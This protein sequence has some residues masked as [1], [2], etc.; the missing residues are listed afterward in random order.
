MKFSSSLGLIIT[1]VIV[2]IFCS[3]EK[4]ID[5]ILSKIHPNCNGVSILEYPSLVDVQNEY[6][7]LKTQLNATTDEQPLI[8]F[9]DQKAFYSLRKKD[10]EMDDGIIPDD[11]DF[12]AWEYTSDEVLATLLNEDGLIIINGELYV[13]SDGCTGFKVPFD[14]NNYDGLVNMIKEFHKDIITDASYHTY[15]TT[16]G[17]ELVNLCENTFDFESNFEGY[18]PENTMGIRS[19]CTLDATIG[20]NILSNNPITKIA[21]IELTA[22]NMTTSSTVENTWYLDGIG[23]EVTIIGGSYPGPINQLWNQAGGVYVGRFLRIRVDYNTI[24]YL[25]VTLASIASDLVCEPDYDVLHI[26]LVCPILL[27]A[28][29]LNLDLGQW[30]FSIEG[31]PVGTPG[32]FTWNFGDGTV[33][34]SSNLSEIHDFGIPCAGSNSYT[35]SVADMEGT[36]PCNFPLTKYVLITNP[37]TVNSFRDTGK[38]RAS[39]KK[40]KYV[41]K[42]KPN[43]KIKSKLKHRVPGKTIEVISGEVLTPQGMNCDRVDLASL[44]AS[45]GQSQRGHDGNPANHNKKR[46]LKQRYKDGRL[47]YVDLNAPYVIRFSTSDGYSF[48]YQKGS[49][50]MQ[51]K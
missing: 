7:Q 36:M 29:P 38:G 35:V 10:Q 17:F 33:I 8:D 22:Y 16:Y 1:L 19:T 5:D 3:C 30:K 14:C 15:L 37:C 23:S 6:N 45:T 12:D 40:V 25:D 2:S 27:N 43:G 46:R 32:L 41:H 26:D 18:E 11:P 44:M 4:E 47:F 20:V 31:L 50:C 39:N 48:D 24:N 13:W 51:I 28:E 49:G 34:Q 21:E 9:E 42:I